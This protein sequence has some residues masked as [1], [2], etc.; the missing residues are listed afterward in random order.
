MIPF[1]PNIR[2][3]T[4]NQSVN[5]QREATLVKTAHDKIKEIKINC[6]FLYFPFNIDLLFVVLTINNTIR[7]SYETS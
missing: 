3:Y 5:K 1:S 4:W 6:Q 7:I 2:K